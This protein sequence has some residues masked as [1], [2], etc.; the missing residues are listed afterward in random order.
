MHFGKSATRLYHAIALREIRRTRIRYSPVDK[1]HAGFL[2]RS[3]TSASVVSL[4]YLR[5][6]L[7]ARQTRLRD[8]YNPIQRLL[9]YIG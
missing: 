7:G 9:H 2:A 5:C 3:Q 6:F 8:L 1:R 4:T